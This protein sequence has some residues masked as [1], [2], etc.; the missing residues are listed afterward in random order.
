MN[1]HWSHYN[2]YKTK[3]CKKEEKKRK[4]TPHSTIAPNVTNVII[5]H[6]AAKKKKK[7]QNPKMPTYEFIIQM[8]I[9]SFQQFVV[10]DVSASFGM[11]F[12][13]TMT[14]WKNK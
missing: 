6:R 8:K 9:I 7:I 4:E 12:A 1:T 2:E 14:N 5:M 13:N 10:Y 3:K 11:L